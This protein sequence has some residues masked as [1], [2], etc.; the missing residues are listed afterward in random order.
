MGLRQAFSEC[1]ISRKPADVNRKRS[2]LARQAHQEGYAI[3]EKGALERDDTQTI[4]LSDQVTS[5][6]LCGNSD[7]ER[8]Y[9]AEHRGAYIRYWLCKTCGLVYQSPRMTEAE[10][11]KFYARQYR[12]LYQ[13]QAEPTSHDVRIQSR[14]ATHLA[15]IV[16]EDDTL[17]I[18]YHL[19]IG[20]GSGALIEAMQNTCGCYSEGIE[21]STAYRLFSID[22][23]LSIYSSLDAWK[24]SSEKRPDLV[25]M[26]HVLEHLMDPIA[27]LKDLRQHVIKRRGYLLVEV[28]NLFVHKSFEL[29]HTFA[30]SPGVLRELVRKAG[31]DI[32]WLKKHG[33]PLKMSPIY[34]TL[35]AQT[36]E[37]PIPTYKLRSNAGGVFYLRAMCRFLL[38]VENAFDKVIRR[39]RRYLKRNY[40]TI[41]GG[42]WH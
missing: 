34:L 19:D 39:G 1:L 24:V 23:G 6:L 28:P 12:T 35:L 36:L 30:F 38:R 10:L 18:E 5:C 2:I 8:F 27:Y 41:L 14:R 25:T 31:F 7:R 11:D 42:I 17:S 33:V 21:P 3:V 26:S 4:V 32:V 13:G 29:A 15:G 22:K 37:D 40:R 20:C 9:Q 16:S